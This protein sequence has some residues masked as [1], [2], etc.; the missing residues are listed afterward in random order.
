[1]LNILVACKEQKVPGGLEFARAD[2]QHVLYDTNASWGVASNNLLAQAAELGG[3]ALF[4][5]D[6]VTLTAGCLD[7]VFSYYDHADVFGLDLHDMT[8]ARQAGARHVLTND[9]GMVDWVQP[10]PAYVAHCSTSAI[11]IKQDVLR[12]NVR[13]PIWDGIHWED[14]VFCLDAWLHGFK[15]LAVLGYVH[16]NIV[17]GAGAT[18]RHAPEF[19]EKWAKN[20][21]YF[22]AWCGERR[23]MQ[24]LAD[25]RVP[26]GARSLEEVTL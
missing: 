17:G 7:H 13:F 6:D 9:G 11:Y 14:V 26:I 24:A 10:G 16:H 12:A 8:G 25:G 3:D 19:W 22:G 21:Q 23:L 2:E 20:R 15:V 4:L 1:M 18:K 5:D